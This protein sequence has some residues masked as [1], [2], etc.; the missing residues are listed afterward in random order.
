MYL[1]GDILIF[2]WTFCFDNSTKKIE[3]QREGI[4]KV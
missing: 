4:N 2:G 3:P 1:L